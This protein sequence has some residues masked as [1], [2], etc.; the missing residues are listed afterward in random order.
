MDKQTPEG[1]DLL[2][3]VDAIFV[4]RLDDDRFVSRGTPAESVTRR[5]PY[6]RQSEP[7]CGL[8]AARGAAA[9]RGRA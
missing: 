1:F 3:V 7:Q 5:V 4:L 9:G 6:R 8:A 2:A